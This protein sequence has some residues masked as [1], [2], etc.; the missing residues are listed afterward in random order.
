MS[1]FAPVPYAVNVNKEI[2]SQKAKFPAAKVNLKDRLSSR[3]SYKRLVLWHASYQKWKKLNLTL[4]NQR[5]EIKIC[6]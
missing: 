1:G 4:I 6:M 2:F 5:V 3:V